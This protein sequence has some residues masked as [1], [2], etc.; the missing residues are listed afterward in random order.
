MNLRRLLGP[1]ARGQAKA[2]SPEDARFRALTEACPAAV[3]IVRDDVVLYANP[4]AGASAGVRREAL[5]GAAFSGLAQPELQ[6]AVRRRATE[7]QRSTT[8]PPQRFE[9][10]LADR[11]SG[12]SWVDLTLTSVQHRGQPAVMA[13]GFDV[14]DRRLAED[15]LR[16]SE[17]RLRDLIENVQLISILVDADGTVS[18]ANEFVLE[19]LGYAEEDVVG[20]DWFDLALPEDRRGGVKE[21][22]LDRIRVGAVAPHDEYEILTARGERRLV[23]WNNTPLHGTGGAVV[24]MASIGADVTERRRAEERLLHDALH[25]ALTALPN[26]ALFMDRLRG[27]V[28]RLRRHPEYLFAVLFLDVD[29]F[30]V[31]ND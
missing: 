25:D 10:R 22:F 14:T 6:D 3:L 29:R 2:I 23:S 21:A 17:R 18:F 30:K 28:A 13:I 11:G 31:I 27:A 4:A 19:L 9:L 12:V 7:Q 1:F 16:E 8:H 15:G 20:R 26:R 5:V 24:G